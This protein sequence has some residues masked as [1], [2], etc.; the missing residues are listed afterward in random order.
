MVLPC[1]SCRQ[2]RAVTVAAVA[3]VVLMA[4]ASCG[5]SRPSTTARPS[6]TALVS[7]TVSATI[8]QSGGRLANQA[9]V[10]LEVPKNMLQAPATASITPEPNGAWDVH[11]AAVWSGTVAVTLPAGN[12]AAHV[13][14]GHQV[15]GVWRVEPAPRH[16]MVYSLPT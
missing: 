2:K 10:V 4:L 7:G 14:L 15:N 8:G 5:V 11:I 9:G 13:L 12:D 3:V 1:I 16:L 6:A